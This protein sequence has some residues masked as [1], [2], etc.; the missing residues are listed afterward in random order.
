[1]E[2]KNMLFFDLCHVN[3]KQTN[4]ATAS[5]DHHPP[6]STTTKSFVI[7]GHWGCWSTPCQLNQVT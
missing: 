7:C 6:P 1:M 3:G 2:N 5:M 4:S